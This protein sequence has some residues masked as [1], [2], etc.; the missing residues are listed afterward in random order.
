[1]LIVFVSSFRCYKTKVSP[2]SFLSFYLSFCAYL[3]LMQAQI[4][5]YFVLFANLG[6]CWFCQV[7]VEK[8]FYVFLF[9]I[10]C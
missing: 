2:S 6:L 10:V 5:F 3:K 8:E 7:T 9:A 1:M 4:I